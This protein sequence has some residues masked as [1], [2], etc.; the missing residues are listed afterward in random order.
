L[1]LLV[2]KTELRRRIG[3]DVGETVHVHLEERL[4]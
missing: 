1:D 4:G 2:V 3:K